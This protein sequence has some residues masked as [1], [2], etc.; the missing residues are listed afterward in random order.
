MLIKCDVVIVNRLA[1]HLESRKCHTTITLGKSSNASMFFILHTTKNKSGTKY[2]VKNNILQVHRRFIDEGKCTISMK[3]PTHD[4][5][6]SKGAAVDLKKFLLVLHLALHD[7]DVSSQVDL[8]NV[9]LPKHCDLE[10]PK[11]SLSIHEKSS[12]PIKTSFPILLEKLE[13]NNCFLKKF[14][15]R[16]LKLVNLKRLDLSSNCLNSLPVS[17]D[18]LT[19]L[20]YICLSNNLFTEFP[21]SLLAVSFTKSLKFLDISSN[22][23]KY[24]PSRLSV[25]NELVTL[26]LAK[27]EIEY[28]PGNFGLLKNLKY[29]Y[30]SGNLLNTI[31]W[32]FQRLRLIHFEFDNALC[33]LYNPSSSICHS[34]ESIHSLF[35]L[36]ARC[37]IKNRVGF[38][39]DL[40]PRSIA[41]QLNNAKFCPCGSPCISNYIPYVKSFDLCQV[42]QELSTDGC[43]AGGKLMANMIGYLC[44]MKCYKKWQINPNTLFTDNE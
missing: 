10:K 11:T 17:M 28:L 29:L 6:I 23:I 27:N 31:P 14:D 34:F 30:T 21:M 32:T 16:I 13:V 8:D 18:M 42:S 9:L 40:I 4:I 35:E 25:L 7:K 26:N 41:T 15:I 19:S 39:T 37:I 12:Y 24:L 38:C 5:V 33:N 44:C 3:E 22:K 20:N 36:A 1:P 43:R 2:L